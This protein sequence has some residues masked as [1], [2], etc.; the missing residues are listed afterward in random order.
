MAAPVPASL[1][2]PHQ[3]KEACSEEAA[4]ASQAVE[5]PE[6]EDDHPSSETSSFSGDESTIMHGDES[7][8]DMADMGNEGFK[9]MA[10]FAGPEEIKARMSRDYNLGD[11]PLMVYD[12]DLDDF[13]GTC[14]GEIMSPQLEAYAT[15]TYDS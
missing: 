13:K 1:K 3:S 11:T 10:T 9:L 14:P 7:V 12:I 15:T 4:M 6:H 8:A 2:G 5:L